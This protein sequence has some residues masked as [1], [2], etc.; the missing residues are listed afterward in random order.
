MAITDLIP[1][2][3]DE[4][5][6][7]V[8]REEQE[9]FYALQR[10]MNRLFDDFFNGFNLA[11]FDAFGESFGAFSPRVD[12]SE[13]DKEIKVAAELPGLDENDIEVSLSKNVLTISGEK[14]E[15]KEDKGQNYYRVERSYGS[16]RRSIPLPVEVESDKVEATFK[17]GI[18]TVNLPKTAAA[19]KQA[20]Q[21]FVKTG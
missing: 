20:K 12:V 5:K 15:K 19:Q 6:V 3:R 14:K 4:K 2:K 16:F 8:K 18:L 7:P 13:S 21:I 1:W 9:P 11:P 17:K 10:N